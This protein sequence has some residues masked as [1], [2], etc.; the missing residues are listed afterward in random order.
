M[1]TA[2]KL[3][4]QVDLRSL[5]VGEYFVEDGSYYPVY[6]VRQVGVQGQCGINCLVAYDM[7]T[8]EEDEWGYTDPNFSPF[9]IKVEI[10]KSKL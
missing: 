8:G 3:L 1:I 9:V 10:D 5:Q 6:C 4:D 7:D 2:T